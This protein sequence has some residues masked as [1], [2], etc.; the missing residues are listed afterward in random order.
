MTRFS[1][2]CLMGLFSTSLLFA[3]NGVTQCGT[4]TGQPRF[5]LNTSQE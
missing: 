5:P 4:P 2:L 3:Q 1:I